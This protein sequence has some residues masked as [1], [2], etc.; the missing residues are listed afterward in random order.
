M[1]RIGR[2]FLLNNYEKRFKV[3]QEIVLAAIV[4]EDKA[5]AAANNQVKKQEE[6]KRIIEKNRTFTFAS[7]RQSNLPA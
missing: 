6:Y 4:G 1:D 7:L 3:S 2:E 5:K